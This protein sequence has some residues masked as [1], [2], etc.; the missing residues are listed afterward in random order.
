MRRR[1]RVRE[2][3]NLLSLWED[4]FFYDIVCLLFPCG[5]RWGKESLILAQTDRGPQIPAVIRTCHTLCQRVCNSVWEWPSPGVLSG[6]SICGHGDPALYVKHKLD[7]R[8]YN[9]LVAL[10]AT[11]GMSIWLEVV[12]L[13]AISESNTGCLENEKKRKERKKKRARVVSK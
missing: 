5:G 2:D 12:C 3:L 13:K 11:L 1:Q 7:P 6:H 10:K 8:V 4:F 9:S